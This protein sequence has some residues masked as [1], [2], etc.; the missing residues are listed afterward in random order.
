M[1]PDVTY[2][3]GLCQV[4]GNLLMHSPEEDAFWTFV[5]LMDKHL[6]G[7][8]AVNSLQ[9]EADAMFF[10]KALESNDPQLAAKLFVSVIQP[11]DVMLC[12]IPQ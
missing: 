8:C 12:S 11:N 6:R 9:M 7:Y 4:A 2:S 3:Q 1:V 5:A 10:A